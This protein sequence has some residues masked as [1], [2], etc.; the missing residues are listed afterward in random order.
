MGDQAAMT[1][2]APAERDVAMTEAAPVLEIVKDVAAEHESVGYGNGNA[3]PR[4]DV[5]QVRP[6]VEEVV[7]EDL[8]AEDVIGKCTFSCRKLRRIHLLSRL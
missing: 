1:V 4:L 2:A 5:G 8:I 3:V 6:S 7:V